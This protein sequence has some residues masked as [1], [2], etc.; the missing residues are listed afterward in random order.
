MA[1]DEDKTES[2]EFQPTLTD[3]LFSSLKLPENEGQ[4]VLLR[5]LL[6]GVLN[7]LIKREA[8]SG[9]EVR[10]ILDRAEERVGASSE[11]AK[12]ETYERLKDRGYPQSYVEEIVDRMTKSAESTLSGIRERVINKPDQ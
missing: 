6:E 5:M 4:V 9:E 2:S 12:R 10:V 11:R 7:A 3:T 1:Q 8:L